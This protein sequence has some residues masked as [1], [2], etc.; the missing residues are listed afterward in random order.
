[1]VGSMIAALCAGPLVR[2][3]KL[4]LKLF[5]LDEH[6]KMELYPVSESIG[7]DWLLYLH[8]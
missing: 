1:M 3:L 4:Q 2:L 7:R 5:V 8:G 6:G